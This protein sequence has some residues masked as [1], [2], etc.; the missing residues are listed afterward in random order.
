MKLLF[1]Y[2]WTNSNGIT[3]NNGCNYKTPTTSIFLAI[4]FYKL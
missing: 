3:F 4:N 2:T 1:V